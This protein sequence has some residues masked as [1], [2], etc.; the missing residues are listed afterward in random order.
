[1]L[2]LIINIM[3]Q[4]IDNFRQMELCTNM[5]NN[6]HSEQKNPYKYIIKTPLEYCERL[7]KLYDCNVY[8]KREDKQQIRSFKI[9]GACHNIL[10][11]LDKIKTDNM[12]AV[13]CSAGNH[14]QGVALMCELLNIKCFV[15]VPMSTPQ[16]KINKIK[17]FGKTNSTI[18][19]CGNSFDESCECAQKFC[20]LNNG[21]FI[22]PFDDFATIYG[23]S[24]IMNEIYEQL[25]NPQ[26]ILSPIGGGGL[27]SG[28]LLAK[29]YFN[30]SCKIY[31]AESKTCPSM[32]ISLENGK[33]IKY[34]VTDSFVDGATVGTVGDMT[35]NIC[36]SY[37]NHFDIYLI[38]VG[39][40]C[41][42]IIDLHQYEGIIAEPAGA[43]SIAMLHYMSSDVIKGKNV[44]CVLSGGNNDILRY[45][46][47]VEKGLVYKKLLHYY[48]ISFIQKAGQLRKYIFDV[49]KEDTDIV[50]FEYDKK[51]DSEFGSVILGIQIVDPND[52]YEIEKRMK[53]HMFDFVKMC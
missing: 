36:N 20:E 32:K 43:L 38:D 8:L 40:L 15:F 14:G 2:T 1:M 49:L 25:Q 34:N 35:F 28:L 51:T 47:I 50:K 3:E 7:S 6:T 10:S 37:M 4:H 16:Q 21:I 30:K 18:Y 44:V 23:Q 27:I 22:H 53:E 24:T 39:F 5:Y 52:I 46:E 9:R 17:Y 12:I 41:N 29:Y 11:N 31:G 45:Q 48:K 13:T 19:T 33:I 42:T 26:I